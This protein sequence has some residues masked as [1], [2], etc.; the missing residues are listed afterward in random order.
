VSLSIPTKYINEVM[1]GNKWFHCEEDSFMI[2]AYEFVHER[3]LDDDDFQSFGGQSGVTYAG[4]QFTNDWGFIVSG[5]MTA[6]QCVKWD[7]R[8]VTIG[9][10]AIEMRKENAS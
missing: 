7:D 9:P 5:P 4:F 8:V 3:G 2:D 6:I 10:K 1:I